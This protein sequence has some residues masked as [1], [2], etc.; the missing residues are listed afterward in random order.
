[1]DSQEQAWC[2]DTSPDQG[3]QVYDK[4]EVLEPGYTNWSKKQGMVTTSMQEKWQ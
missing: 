3:V 2:L 4:K 1:M